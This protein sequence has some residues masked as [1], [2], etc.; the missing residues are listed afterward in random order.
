MSINYGVN[1]INLM[2]ENVQCSFCQ[3]YH[4][5]VPNMISGPENIHICNHCIKDFHPDPPE[6]M[7]YQPKNNKRSYSFINNARNQNDQ[8]QN[9]PCSFCGLYHNQ[10]QVNYLIANDNVDAIICDNCLQVCKTAIEDERNKNDENLNNFIAY[11][12]QELSSPMEE[13][14]YQ[15][16]KHLFRSVED[17]LDFKPSEAQKFIPLL[18]MM[19]NLN[20]ISEKIVNRINLI[21]SEITQIDDE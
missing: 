15:K 4:F 20:D 3:R 5:E 16:Q 11:W 7:L 19:L 13:F 10:Q 18:D 2:S 17:W 14:S 12:K 1:G 9:S 21:K 8:P 6:N